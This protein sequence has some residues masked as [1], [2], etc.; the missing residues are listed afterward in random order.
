MAQI[1]KTKYHIISTMSGTSLDGLDIAYVC[2]DIENNKPVFKV[3]NAETIEF[4]DNEKQVLTEAEN[5]STVRFLRFHNAVG[6]YIGEKIN[7]FIKKHHISEVDFIASHG[8]TIFHRPEDNFT[9]QAGNPAYIAAETGIKTV[10]DFRTLDIA[11]KGQGAPLV[12]VGDKYLFS[13]YDAC[14]NIGGIANISFDVSSVRVAFDICPANMVLNYFSKKFGQDFDKDGELGKQ[15][16]IDSA[17]LVELNNIEYY[18]KRWPKS[19][20][21]EWFDT[22]FLPL[23]KKHNIDNHNILRTIYEHISI[24]IADSLNNVQGKTVLVTGGGAFNKFLIEEI[25]KKTNK[26]IILPDNEIIEYKE[27]IIFAFLG[28]LRILEKEN[29]LSSVTGAIKNSCGGA[30]YLG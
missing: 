25:K 4:T 29:T 22:T 14:L 11:Y 27:S 26:K 17:L 7:N 13:E 16:H 28:L 1:S 5:F 21:K 30:V 24:Q 8:H 3:I 9:F 19:L 23:I 20:S 15:G 10:A 2:F 12:P 18:S 6:K